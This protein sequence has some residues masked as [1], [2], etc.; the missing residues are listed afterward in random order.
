MV[1]T[2]PNST[3]LDHGRADQAQHTCFP[4]DLKSFR[5]RRYN[6][7]DLFFACHALH[8]HTSHTVGQYTV[9]MKDVLG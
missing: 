9:K 5:S 2:A 8:L 6:L 3:Y 7:H 1:A 4:P